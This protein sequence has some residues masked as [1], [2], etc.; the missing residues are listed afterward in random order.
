MAGLVEQA[1]QE[2]DERVSGLL[3]SIKMKDDQVRI[4]DDGRLRGES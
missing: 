4:Y 1:R 2:F 3:T